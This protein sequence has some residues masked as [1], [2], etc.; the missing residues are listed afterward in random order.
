MRKRRKTDKK[1]NEKSRAPDENRNPLRYSRVFVD[2][3]FFHTNQFR[4][5]KSYP[6][7]LIHLDPCVAYIFERNLIYKTLDSTRS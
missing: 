4:K 6:L 5:V 7:V 2:S 3:L 1:D